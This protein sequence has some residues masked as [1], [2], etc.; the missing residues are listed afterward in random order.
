[1][2]IKRACTVTLPNHNY[3]DSLVVWTANNN[4]LNNSELP[5]SK[6]LSKLANWKNK[7]THFFEF[8][9]Y[10]T[11]QHNTTHANLYIHV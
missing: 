5:A 8:I 1:M 10:N 4:S 2:I 7:Y 9:Q 6:S 3:K 11:L